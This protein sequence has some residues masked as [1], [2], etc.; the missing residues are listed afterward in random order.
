MNLS[1]LENQSLAILAD[2]A[3]QYLL[4][5]LISPVNFIANLLVVLTIASSKELRN[6]SQFVILSHSACEMY[7]ALAGLGV[8]IGYYICFLYHWPVSATRLTCILSNAP[9]IVGSRADIYFTAALALDRLTC[10]ALPTRFQ[11]LPLRKYIWAMNVVCWV[12]A[13]LVTTLPAMAIGEYETVVAFCDIF[14]YVPAEVRKWD[15][16]ESNAEAGLIALMYMLNAALLWRRYKQAD[17]IG[18]IQKSEWRRQ[19][20]FSVF[21]AITAIGVTFLITAVV[22]RL[23]FSIAAT[24]LVFSATTASVIG[25][26]GFFLRSIS[27]LFYCLLFNVTF[28]DQFLRLFCKRDPNVVVSLTLPS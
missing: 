17:L 7:Y 28:R 21:L 20:D 24:Y 22:P 3:P 12:L 9:Q 26:L 23:F 4:L 14:A 15:S 16:L 19:M 27:N 5:I 1:S 2:R 13:I 11:S 8:G 6:K 25:Y 18:E 10:M